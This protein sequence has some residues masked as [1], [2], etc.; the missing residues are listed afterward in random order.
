MI[1]RANKW[2]QAVHD[3]C[4]KEWSKTG[5]PVPTNFDRA[6]YTFEVGPFIEERLME[7]L[8]RAVGSP[9]NER[10]QLRTWQS[11]CCRTVKGVISDVWWNKL[12][13]G[14]TEDHST[15]VPGE[16]RRERNRGTEA[17]TRS[18]DEAAAVIARE[19]EWARAVRMAVGK[20]HAAQPQVVENAITAAKAIP[21]TAGADFSA[22]TAVQSPARALA[23]TPLPPP[24]RARVED[25][26]EDGPVLNPA[27]S[28]LVV[29]EDRA[30][31][32]ALLPTAEPLDVSAGVGSEQS[33]ES[34][35]ATKAESPADDAVFLNSV[36]K[37][38]QDPTGHPTMS[39]RQ[40]AHVI[41]RHEST[42]RRLEQAEKLQAAG[43]RT[44][45]VTTKSVIEYIEHKESD[46]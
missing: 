33:P 5:K 26:V 30:E 14:R 27:P 31:P 39:R 32:A 45:R 24:L 41:G 37:C 44:G 19:Q 8:L 22:K 9:P 18:L 21:C 12:M 25:I 10:K 15:P 23:P 4:T 20:P 35:T 13:M 1:E 40:A 46:T 28:A 29:E 7:L 2:I 38:L 16:A 43:V 11:Q 34:A 17:P 42:V 3:V 6:V 36:K